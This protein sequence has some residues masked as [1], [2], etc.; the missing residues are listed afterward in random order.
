MSAGAPGP[1]VFRFFNE[2]GIIEQ[3]TRNRLERRLPHGLKLS[4]FT[5]L[6]H[7]MRLGG[8]WAPAR[9]AR[10]F[11]V[12]KG[13]MTN[14]IQRLQALGFVEVLPDP[15]DRR[16]KRVR[17]TAAGRTAHA[18]ALVALGPDLA[19]IE[20]ALGRAGFA[21][22]IPFLVEVRSYLDENRI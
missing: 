21:A 14:T 9:L 17:I 19:T 10:A 18:D 15:A 3:L 7:L 20:G 16:G 1:D 22:A 12:T 2:V 5:L 11:Q 8:E 13:A 4:Q 6:N